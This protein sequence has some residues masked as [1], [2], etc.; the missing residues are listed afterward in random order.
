MLPKPTESAKKSRKHART[1]SEGASVS[2]PSFKTRALPESRRLTAAATPGSPGAASSAAS[3]LPS[4]REGVD[5]WH[6]PEVTIMPHD[7]RAH[8]VSVLVQYFV[9]QLAGRVED[10]TKGC[11]YERWLDATNAI[12]GAVLMG[13]LENLGH[14]PTEYPYASLVAKVHKSGQNQLNKKGRGPNAGASDAVKQGKEAGFSEWQK[15]WGKFFDAKKRP[16]TWEK[17]IDMAEKYE[18]GIRPDPLFFTVKST[19]V[20]DTMAKHIDASFSHMVA[21]MGVTLKPAQLRDVIEAKMMSN[22]AAIVAMTRSFTSAVEDAQNEHDVVEPRLA[23]LAA[24]KARQDAE[25]EAELKALQ[26]EEAASVG[27]TSE[28]AGEESSATV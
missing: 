28:Q 3:E 24:K 6:A 22:Q 21:G 26:A 10:A 25:Y 4:D 9:L 7:Y 11:R 2:T 8:L 12:V 18:K 16:S 5:E 20:T 19:F 15:V 17:L 1:P 13:L 27:G 23:E 14:V